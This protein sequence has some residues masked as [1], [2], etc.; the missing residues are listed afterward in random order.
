[1]PCRSEDKTTSSD[2]FPV[3]KARPT[4]LVTHGQCK[5]DVSPQRS[6]SL[7]NPENDDDTKRV[8]QASGNWS[9]SGSNFE[10]EK[11]AHVNRQEKVHLA[12]RKLGQKDRTRA[13]SE[14]DSSRTRKLDASL[15]RIGEHEIL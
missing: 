10:V 12:H 6:G 8:I 15:T 14:E 9:I 2:G 11:N 4:N 3:A 1:M 5:E 7:V 13:K